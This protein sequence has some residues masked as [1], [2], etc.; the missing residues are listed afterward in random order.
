MKVVGQN[1][2]GKSIKQIKIDLCKLEQDE[3]YPYIDPLPNDVLMVTGTEDQFK[4]LIA[5][6]IRAV[7][8]DRDDPFT[9]GYLDKQRNEALI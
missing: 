1:L 8:S 7:E 4:S 3:R 9:I 2:E 6:V 5:L